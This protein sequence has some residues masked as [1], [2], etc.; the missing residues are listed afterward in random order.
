MK[1]ANQFEK[2]LVGS[3]RGVNHRNPIIVALALTI[4]LT[5]FTAIN[6]GQQKHLFNPFPNYKKS[7]VLEKR[8]RVLPIS[9]YSLE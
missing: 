1:K 3:E 6:L 7:M 5:L 4:L 2:S 9:H 8:N